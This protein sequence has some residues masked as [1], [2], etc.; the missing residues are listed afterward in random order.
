[1]VVPSGK[2]PGMAVWR[3][4]PTHQV[5]EKLQWFC[6]LQDVRELRKNAAPS[7]VGSEPAH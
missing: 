4:V 5:P 6:V 7:F 1:M 2:V 3:D